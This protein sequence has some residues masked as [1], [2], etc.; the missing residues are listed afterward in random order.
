ML[1][2][3]D[4]WP[5][6]SQ[7]NW[8]PTPRREGTTGWTGNSRSETSFFLMSDWL[9]MPL[10]YTRQLENPISFCLE[11]IF[12]RLVYTK[13]YQYPDDEERYQSPIVRA[14]NFNYRK[15]CSV[16][17]GEATG[18]SWGRTRPPKGT[19]IT[20]ELNPAL[21]VLVTD[22]TWAIDIKALPVTVIGT[23][24]R[25]TIRNCK[26][27]WTDN[28]YVSHITAFKGDANPVRPIRGLG[29]PRKFRAMGGSSDLLAKDTESHC[30]TYKSE[31]DLADIPIKHTRCER[32]DSATAAA[33]CSYDNPNKIIVRIPVLPCFLV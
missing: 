20:N 32:Q 2:A 17:Q 21:R 30:T 31:I 11:L 16:Y 13:K 26:S 24:R 5:S 23:E 4:Y 6:S 19:G 14:S 27:N 29:R 9:W 10:L 3:D 12:D 28:I 33:G 22:H 7:S 25:R 8:E 1:R 18:D 15:H